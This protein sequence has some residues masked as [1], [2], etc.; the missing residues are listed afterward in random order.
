M[1]NILIILIVSE[2]NTRKTDIERVLK[3]ISPILLVLGRNT[4]EAKG[5]HITSYQGDMIL[6]SLITG[7]VNLD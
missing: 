7:E 2:Q 3:N 4:T 6:T 1:N 5:P